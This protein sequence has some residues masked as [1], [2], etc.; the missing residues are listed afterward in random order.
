MRIYKNESGTIVIDG[1]WDTV[2]HNGDPLMINHMNDVLVTN[3]NFV[4]YE[5]E[6]LS[7]E[8]DKSRKVIVVA[9]QVKDPLPGEDVVV[10]LSFNDHTN[11]GTLSPVRV[12]QIAR[13]STSGIEGK[14]VAL[15]KSIRG[16]HRVQIRPLKTNESF[17]SAASSNLLKGEIIELR[18]VSENI[19]TDK[20][21]DENLAL[22]NLL[23]C[24]AVKDP[25]RAELMSALL[26]GLPVLYC[27]HIL[28]SDK[29]SVEW[30]DTSVSFSTLTRIKCI[31]EK[32][33]VFPELVILYPSTTFKP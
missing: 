5:P 8:N 2:I 22:S 6:T 18:E 3:F 1:Q 25:T 29:F 15:D 24:D 23:Q 31:F 12:G 14:V 33:G 30:R 28:N 19:N 32:N 17:V 21:V 26:K 7:M 11:S 27:G 10:I 4:K 13:V 16:I 20:L 9:N